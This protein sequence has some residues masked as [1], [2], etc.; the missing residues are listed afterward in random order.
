MN[1]LK[2][3]YNQPRCSVYPHPQV[4][5][6]NRHRASAQTLLILSWSAFATTH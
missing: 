5:T 2:T 3:Y 6:K 1:T 4:F